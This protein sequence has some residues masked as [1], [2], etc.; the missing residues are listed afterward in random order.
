LLCLR[1]V[2]TGVEACALIE[3]DD[4]TSRRGRSQASVTKW[5][6]TS[7]ILDRE[8][9]DS[10]ISRNVRGGAAAA[11]HFEAARILELLRAD[12]GEVI[13]KIVDAEAFPHYQ[14]PKKPTGQ[15]KR[16]AMK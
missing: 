13:K 1:I 15:K 5:S 3:A 10:L 12:I 7:S 6:R 11:K 14:I 4:P 8:E 16:R 2:R 9:N